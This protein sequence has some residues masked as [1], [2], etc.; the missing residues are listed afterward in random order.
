MAKEP[1]FKMTLIVYFTIDELKA[2]LFEKIARYHFR[3]AG[4]QFSMKFYK[5]RIDEPGESY[6]C[7]KLEIDGSWVKRPMRLFDI[8]AYLQTLFMQ[9]VDITRHYDLYQKIN[10]DVIKKNDKDVIPF[11]F[12]FI[13][14]ENLVFKASRAGLGFEPINGMVTP[15]D[16][17]NLYS[18]EQFDVKNFENFKKPKSSSVDTDDDD[19]DYRDND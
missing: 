8:K 15:G 1:Y 4:V 12:K 5:P 18:H 2:L 19:F 6:Y 10:T 11:N 7:S 17:L 14:G 3:D 16:V 13:T 9:L